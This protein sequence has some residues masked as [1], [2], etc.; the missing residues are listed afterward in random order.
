MQISAKPEYKTISL[1]TKHINLMVEM[2]APLLPEDHKRPRQ[3]ILAALD[4]SGSMFGNKFKKVQ[5]STTK[6]INQL[7]DDDEFG[8]VWF[9]QGGITHVPFQRMTEKIGRAHV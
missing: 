6:L 5:Q 4:C 8:I 7:C 3:R 1:E 9:G 2:N